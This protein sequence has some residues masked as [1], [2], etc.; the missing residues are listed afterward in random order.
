MVQV[1]LVCKPLLHVVDDSVV[2]V[3]VLGGVASNVASHKG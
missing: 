2:A 1:N 3:D